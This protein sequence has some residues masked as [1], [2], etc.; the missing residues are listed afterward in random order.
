MSRK[1]YLKEAYEEE[2]QKAKSQHMHRKLMRQESRARQRARTK[3][4][5]RYGKG[6][7][8]IGIGRTV[9]KALGAGTKATVKYLASPPKKKSSSSGG[10]KKSKTRYVVQGG[11]AYPVASTGSGKK[12]SK[13]KGKPFKIAAWDADWDNPTGYK[14]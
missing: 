2:Y 13:K 9:G 12:T 6:T 3:A 10:H 1:D 7:A 14:F 8:A 11:R 5:L 4:T